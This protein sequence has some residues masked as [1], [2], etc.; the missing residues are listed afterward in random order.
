M[1]AG[2]DD[3]YR[4]GRGEYV[5]GK[6]SAEKQCFHRIKYTAGSGAGQ[7]HGL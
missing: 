5:G 6:K 2:R 1:T 7:D 3:S 4:G